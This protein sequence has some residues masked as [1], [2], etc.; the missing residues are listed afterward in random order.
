MDGRRIRPL[1][2]PPY[3]RRNRYIPSS[4][5][6]RSIPLLR[7]AKE[8]QKLHIRSSLFPLRTKARG[9]PFGKRRE[10]TRSSPLF[11]LLQQSV[12]RFA[13]KENGIQMI[14]P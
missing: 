2:L 10:E 13:A 5:E 1:F 14:T 11:L 7:F 4:K 9:L 8:P 12:R 6:T 3:P